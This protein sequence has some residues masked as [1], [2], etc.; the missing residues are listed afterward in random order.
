MSCTV[1]MVLCVCLVYVFCASQSY[2]VKRVG[3]NIAQFGATVNF[4]MHLWSLCIYRLNSI[5][6]SGLL[7]LIEK[8]DDFFVVLLVADWGPE[9]DLFSV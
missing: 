8:V 4:L 9:V 7:W 2:K 5:S 3:N 1:V 6:E